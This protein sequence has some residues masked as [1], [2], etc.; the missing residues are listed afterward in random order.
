[1]D[2]GRMIELVR[3]KIEDNPYNY[4][5]AEDYFEL[6]RIYADEGK[7]GQ[8]HKLNKQVQDITA[9]GVQHKDIDIGIK[10]YELH[11]RSLLFSA[12]DD[13]DSYMQY[14]EFNRP[15]EK[16]F[17]L[18][19]RRVLKT[20]VG[21]MQDL[22]DGIIKFLAVSL[23]PR[24]GKS[25]LGCFFISMLMGKY[26]DLANVMTGYGDK[27]TDGF[28]MEVMS[29]LTDDSQYLWR[30]IFPECHVART[31]SKNKEIDINTPK[32]FSTLTCRTMEGALT[33]AVE[34][35]KCLYCDDLVKDLEEALSIERMEKKYDIYAN[36]LRDRML[37]GLGRADESV[38]QL[39]I[40]TRW[41]PIDVMGRIEEIYA[42]DPTY[43][44][45]VIPALNEKNES[46][47]QYKV[48]GFSTA[49]YLDIRDNVLK[50]DPASWWAKYMGRP[51]VREGLL[52]P[53]DDLQYYNGILPD[54]E[55]DRK[56]AACDVAWGGGDSL[57][58]PIAYIYGDECYIVDVVFNRG[59]KEITRAIVV[60]KIKQHL[61]HQVRFEAN[62]GG[63][64]YADKV[65]ELLRDDGIRI[66]ISH[67]KAPNTQSKLSRI[68][69]FAPDIKKFYF[70]HAK[71]RTQEY[72]LFMK[73]LISF[74]QTGKNKYDDAPD[75][76][77]MLVDL[78]DSNA[79]KITVFKRPF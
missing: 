68:V 24:T 34:V 4:Q 50:D 39:M 75:S 20:L 26:P 23:P 22:L 7:A 27:L 69:Q 10:F 25:T 9:Q 65:D 61:P 16:K 43:R 5:A 72:D 8:A 11:K 53:P 54:G 55:P 12:Q 73:E 42:D 48:R 32:R 14:M 45:R 33:G 36:Q 41:T 29:L 37:D 58:M 56:I 15:P 6:L 77:G 67:R 18:P 13:F 62:N 38:F 46:N 64:E 40:G 63:D 66:N 3:Y 30:D 57:S 74:T 35:G 44:F 47:F 71:H 21:D 60:G 51:Y 28:Y 2:T 49:Y 59:H 1:M 17:Y 76:L 78:M 31:N 52:F 70:L 19:R 79:G